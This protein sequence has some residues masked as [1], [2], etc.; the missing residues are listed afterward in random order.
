M[1]ILPRVQPVASVS[2]VG[3]GYNLDISVSPSN[4]INYGQYPAPSYRPQPSDWSLAAHHAGTVA[5]PIAGLNFLLTIKATNPL[6]SETVT[7]Q[8][9]I[10]GDCSGRSI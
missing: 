1:W 4:P 6:N 7:H 2:K 5:N 8:A 9:T 3:W 10:K